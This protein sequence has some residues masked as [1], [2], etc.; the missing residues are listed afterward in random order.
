MRQAKLASLRMQGVD[1][2]PWSFMNKDAPARFAIQLASGLAL[3]LP[4]F[5]HAQSLVSNTVE[6]TVPAGISNL[7]GATV[8][9]TDQDAVYISALT[10]AVNTQTTNKTSPVITGAAGVSSLPAGQTLQVVVGSATYSVVPAADGAWSI[11]TA[12]AP[13]ASGSFTPY[14]NGVYSILATITDA[15]GNTANDI[16]SNELTVLTSSPAAPT[17]EILLDT[18]NDGFINIA[19]KGVAT[20]TDVKINLPLTGNLAVLGDTLTVELDTNGDTTVDQTVVRVLTAGDISAGFFTVPSVALPADSLTL[21]ALATI[22][23]AAA[24]ASPQASDSA[25]LD[26]T[27]PTVPVVNSQT[28]SNTSP[29]ITGTSGTGAALGL[30]ETLV[31]QVGGAIYSVTPAS[32]GS[33]S[34][35]TSTATPTSGTFTAL[36]LGPNNVTATVVDIAGNPTSDA[37]SGEVT[38]IAVVNKADLSPLKPRLGGSGTFVAINQGRDVLFTVQNNLTSLGVPTGPSVG[39]ITLNLPI[40]FGFK[41]EPYSSSDGIVR[42]GATDYA[43]NNSDWTVLSQNPSRLVLETNRVFQPNDLSRIVLRV[44]ATRRTAKA[45]ITIKV[46]KNADLTTS[47]GETKVDN[48]SQV[49]V[50]SVT[51]P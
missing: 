21:I 45:T 49:E 22:K 8:S 1:R 34:I 3:A 27:P 46:D 38:V 40:P 37:T 15:G 19:E 36:P 18:N 20:T 42:I 47:G 29:L 26:L 41:Y 13:V 17:V 12:N 25:K 16:T 4:G 43:T 50:I 23:N 10:P 9:A 30:G 35:N 7:G 5:V 24:S 28:T 6:V 2:K 51:R 14:V 11:D 33:W 32:D 31:V 48:N 39:K 44:V